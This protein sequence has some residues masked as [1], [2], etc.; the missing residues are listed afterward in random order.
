MVR[1]ATP[2]W[3]AGAVADGRETI[4]LRMRPARHSDL[5]RIWP[6]TLQTAWDDLPD[7]ERQ[8]LDRRKWEQHFRKKIERFVEGNRTEKWIA[9]GTSGEFFGYLILGESSFLTQETHAFVYDIWVAPE[10]RGKGIGKR[11][12]EWASGWARERGHRKIKLEVGEGNARARHVYESSGF[13]E[14]RRYMGKSLK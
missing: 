1:P 4:D 9:E 3:V 2:S 6:A 10:H 7:E 13:R 12:I 11:L 5:A 14:E 8:G